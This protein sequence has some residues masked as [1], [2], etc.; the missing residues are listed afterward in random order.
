MQPRVLAANYGPDWP[1]ITALLAGENGYMHL[2]SLAPLALTTK[3]IIQET[4]KKVNNY[5]SVTIKP[6]D[7]HTE[8]SPPRRLGY[9]L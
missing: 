9:I 8:E 7:T 1:G 5:Q 6:C 3:T 4:G 2:L